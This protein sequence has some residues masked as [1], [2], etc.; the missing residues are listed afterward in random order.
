MKIYEMEAGFHTIAAVVAVAEHSIDRRFAEGRPDELDREQLMEYVK[1]IREKIVEQN[2]EKPEIPGSYPYKERGGSGMAPAPDKECVNCGKCAEQCPVQA[3][4]TV[5]PQKVDREACIS[6]M[7]CVSV[8]PHF[9][10]KVNA[11]VLTAVSQM[12]EKVCSVRKECE[13][14]L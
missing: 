7:R 11:D 8:C 4:D 9:A 1:K 3:I 2:M 14:F 13:L 10:R 6:C 5:N 12:L